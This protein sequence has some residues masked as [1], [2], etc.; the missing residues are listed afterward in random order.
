MIMSIPYTELWSGLLVAGLGASL[1]L[2]LLRMR[3]TAS[4]ASGVPHSGAAL[5]LRLALPCMSLAAIAGLG[6]GLVMDNQASGLAG[7]VVLIIQTVLLSALRWGTA[8]EAVGRNPL[9]DIHEILGK[10]DAPKL[11]FHFSDADLPQPGHVLMW[12]E[13]LDASA[14]SWYVICRERKHHEWFVRDGRYASVLAEK[15]DHLPHALHPEVRVVVYANNAQKNRDMLQAA[16]GLTHVQ[17]LHGDSDKPPSFS[18]LTRNFG[19]VFVSGQMGEDRYASNGVFIP[20]EKFVHVGRP[21]AARIRIDQRRGRIGTII[22]M[23]TWFGQF[24]DTQYSSLDRAAD[25][26]RSI[27]RNAPGAEIIVKPHPLSFRHPAWKSVKIGMEKAM[28][29]CKA[30]YAPA[31]MD[32]Y[33]AY[34]AAD[35]LVTDI[36]STVIDYLYAGKP[37]VVILPPGQRITPERF[38]SLGGSYLVQPDLSD[39]DAKFISA[40]KD[41]P[42]AHQREKMR[43]YAYGEIGEDAEAP[44]IAA[45]HALTGFQPRKAGFSA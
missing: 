42:L 17:M 44:F 1:L 6:H 25:I 15:T 3:E 40:I 38:P 45:I 20:K 13:H 28:A 26:I 32:A 9:L 12:A 33:A 10:L 35:M 23:P 18:P 24:G 7:L 34:N 36:S 31:D 8:V 27:R 11:A 2:A 43:K 30:C 5:F 14:V 37:Q 39:M 22:Y 41:D 21:Q 19:K 16:P 4:L 29:E